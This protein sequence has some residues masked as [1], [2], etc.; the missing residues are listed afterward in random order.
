VGPDYGISIAAVYRLDEKGEIIS[1]KGAGG[2]SPKDANHTFRVQEAR[3]AQGWYS[4]IT[5][6][7]FA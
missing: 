4:G 3:Y 1:V 6:D 7:T 5:N 2:V